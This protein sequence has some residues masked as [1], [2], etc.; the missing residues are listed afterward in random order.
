MEHCHRTPKVKQEAKKW[1]ITKER[2]MEI[3]GSALTSHMLPIKRR[4]TLYLN[5]ILYFLTHFL[6]FLTCSISSSDNPPAL[7]SARTCACLSGEKF[8]KSTVF[9]T[10]PKSRTNK[11]FRARAICLARLFRS[12]SLSLTS[13]SRKE[14]IFTE[15]CSLG[16][17]FI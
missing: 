3:I 11:G 16:C 4:A 10:F 8:W 15:D 13:G 5:C 6:F 14:G 17:W 9:S 1:L 7:N 2:E 12:A